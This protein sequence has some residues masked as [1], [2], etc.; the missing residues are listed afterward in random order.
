[1]LFNRGIFCFRF[2]I[3]CDR[4]QDWF[5][6]RCVGI[7]KC[8]ADSLDVYICPNCQKSNQTHHA[9]NR[10]VLIDKDFDVLRRLVKGLQV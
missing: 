2:Y 4:C 8:E 9:A 5:H 6:G 1:V 10:K 7:T 3:G